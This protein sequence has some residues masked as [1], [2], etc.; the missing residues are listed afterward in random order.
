MD[1]TKILADLGQELEHIDEA[2][3]SLERLTRGHGRRRG[4]PPTWITK[5]TIKR[6]RPPGAKKKRTAKDAGTDT[7]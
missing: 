7:S 2:I 6:G 1:L 3:L 5:T 4:R